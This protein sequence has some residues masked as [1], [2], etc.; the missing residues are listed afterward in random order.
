M[1]APTVTRVTNHIGGISVAGSTDDVIEVLNPAT[2]TVIGSFAASNAQDVDRAVRAARSALPAW[3]ASTPAE[4][5]KVLHRLASLVEEN[6]EELTRLEVIDA[7]KPL[8]AANTEEVPGILAALRYFAGAG[9]GSVAQSAGEYCPDSTQYTRREPLGVVAGITP[10][11]FPL[12]QAVWKLAPALATGNT[13]VLKPA[14]NTPMSITR[15]AELAA[16]ILPAGVLNV[17][18]G[19]GSEAGVAL[20]E[21]PGVDMVSFTGSTAAGR[22]IAQRAGAAPKRVVM[23]LGGNAPVTIFDDVDLEKA[24]PSLTNA[25]LFNAG[26]ECMSATR[27]IVAESVVDQLVEALAASLSG[28]VLGDTLDP[29]TTLGPVISER[30]RDRIERL[31]AGRPDRSELVV[32]GKRPDLP[33]FYVSPTLV[34]GVEQHD[35]IVQEEIFGPVVTVQTFTD[36]ADAIRKANDVPY[37]LASSVWTRDVGRVHRMIRALDFGI[38]W[39]NQH[40]V[41]GPDLPIGGFK[42]S[43]YGKEGGFA[44]VDEFTRTKLVSISLD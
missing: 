15:F 16:D 9:R 4:R 12:W 21:H 36:E 24:L 28:A 42:A 18:H 39:V 31:V 11:N 26:Q 27:L 17:V 8:T 14:E 44:G 41:V 32:G 37:G 1:S 2:A 6:A 19:R 10:W 35:E 7:G 22:S 20:V 25:A 38:V 33:G 5:S 29:M 3:S 30:Q 43:G 23:E 40:L 13:V 34:R